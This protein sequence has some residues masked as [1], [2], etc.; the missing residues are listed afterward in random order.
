VILLSPEPVETG[1]GAH[2]LATGATRQE[3]SAAARDALELPG[4]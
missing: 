4:G 3:A 2:L 1:R